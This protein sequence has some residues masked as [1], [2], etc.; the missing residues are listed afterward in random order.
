MGAGWGWG[1]GAA[2]ALAG[3]VLVGVVAAPLAAEA[4]RNSAK[5]RKIDK[6]IVHFHGVAEMADD[7]GDDLWRNSTLGH[8][9]RLETRLFTLCPEYN[10]PTLA[11]RVAKWMNDAAIA[12]GKAFLRYMTFG[13][14]GV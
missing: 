2:R 7:R 9:D 3:W 13:A 4:G 10:R 14:Y 11:Q 1:K 8:I 5:C 12:G 6:Q